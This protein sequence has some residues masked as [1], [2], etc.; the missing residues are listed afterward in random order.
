MPIDQQNMFSDNQ[1]ITASALS[2]VID[3]GN[4]AT[5]VMGNLAPADPGQSEINVEARVTADFA[6]LT[7]LQVQ[8]EQSAN[9]DGS[10]GTVLLQTAAI[11]V[12][13]LKKGYK[14]ALGSLPAGISQRYLVLNYAVVGSNATTGKVTAYLSAHPKNV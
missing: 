1:A 4:P 3:M 2:S 11:P 10:A 14:F 7:S 8:L 6:T 12:A 9:A 5:D 13:T